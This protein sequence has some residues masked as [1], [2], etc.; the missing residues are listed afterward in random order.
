MAEEH[1]RRRSSFFPKPVE[2][3]NDDRL[4]LFRN[5][6][7]VDKEKENIISK[8]KLLGGSSKKDIKEYTEKFKCKKKEFPKL[9]SNKQEE[10]FNLKEKLRNVKLEFDWETASEGLTSYERDFAN[11]R[12]D[13]KY[14]VEK[15]Q[16]LTLHNALMKRSNFELHSILKAYNRLA[17]EEVQKLQSSFID[18]IVEDSGVCISYYNSDSSEMSNAE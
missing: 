13:Y 7:W 5:M 12:P 17:N 3:S 16:T 2:E 14:L 1:K 9:I 18:K 10:R 8:S 6:L 15:V 4:E 11:D